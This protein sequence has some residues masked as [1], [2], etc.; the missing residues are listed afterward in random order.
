MDSLHPRILYATNG[1][2]WHRGSREEVENVN[3]YRQMD[4]E[5]LTN[6]I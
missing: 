6:E 5:R 3:I 2:R 4:D 1:W